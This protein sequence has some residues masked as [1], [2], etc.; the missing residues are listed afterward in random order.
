MSS[1]YIDAPATVVKATCQGLSSSGALAIPG[2]QVGDVIVKIVPV[3]FESGFEGTV[4]VA[5]ELQQTSNL[6]WSPVNFTFILLRGV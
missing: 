5:D 3:G 4:S 1:T 2:L 6:D